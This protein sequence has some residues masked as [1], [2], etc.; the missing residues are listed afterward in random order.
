VPGQDIHAQCVL[1]NHV[2]VREKS[3]SVQPFPEVC[4]PEPAERTS[5]N[6]IDDGVY[7][8]HH[9]ALFVKI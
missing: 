4:G 7:I 5:G 3:S 8:R 2:F 6:K 1:K 9:S